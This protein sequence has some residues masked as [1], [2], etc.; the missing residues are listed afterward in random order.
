MSAENV[1]TLRSSEQIVISLT[2]SPEGKD[3]VGMTFDGKE[4]ILLTAK[5][6]ILAD[7]IR[8]SLKD[9]FD[10]ESIAGPAF[11]WRESINSGEL[12]LISRVGESKS[13]IGIFVPAERFDTLA[14][15]LMGF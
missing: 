6:A 5:T 3:C 7:G 10:T 9:N 13:A 11:D 2:K 1:E 14:T 12:V 4:W 15:H 8:Q